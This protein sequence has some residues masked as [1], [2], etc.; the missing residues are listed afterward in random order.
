MADG[1]RTRVFYARDRLHILVE[2]DDTTV[3]FH[4]RDSSG[5]AG[6]SDYEYSIRVDGGQLRNALHADDT[7]DL[8]DLV[9]TRADEIMATGETSWLRG[10]GVEY[11]VDTRY[12]FDD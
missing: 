5:W 4:G 2:Y 3:T 9:C 10:R 1:R 11:T 8:G 12:G 6:T 7:A